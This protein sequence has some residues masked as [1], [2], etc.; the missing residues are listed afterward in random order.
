MM[1]RS[2][3]LMVTAVLCTAFSVSVDANLTG[4]FKSILLDGNLDDWSN[5]AD[6]LYDPVEISTDGSPTNSV[7][8]N[9]YL[10]NDAANLYVALEMKGT[11][12]ADITN[13]WRH[14]IYLDTDSFGGTG[15]NAGWMSHGYDRLIQYGAGGA[16]TVYE[17]TGG[18]LEE[19]GWNSLGT[20]AYASD[21]NIVEFSIPLTTLNLSTNSFV[22]ELSVVE[23]GVT[24]ETWAH[25]NEVSAET[26]TLAEFSG[27][28]PTITVDGSLEEWDNPGHILYT[29]AEIAD[30]APANSSYENVYV[31]NDAATLYIGLDTKGTGGGSVSNTWTHNIYLDT[32]MNSGT[33][34]KGGGKWMTYGYDRLIQYGTGGTTYSVYEFTGADQGDWEWNFLAEI[35]YAYSDDVIEMS[36]PMYLLNLS[37]NT[38]VMELNVTGGEVTT[39]TWA[40]QWESGAKTYT[41]LDNGEEPPI[42]PIGSIVIAGP[43]SIPG[44]QGMALSWNTAAGQSYS[45]EHTFN[46]TS[47]LDWDVYT[48][49]VGS[50]GGMTVTTSVDQAKSFYQ[51]V[52]P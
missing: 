15:F 20:F 23:G 38:L 32:D 1:K 45:V 49:V 7:Y 34:F 41:V 6:V 9:V 30:G 50:G 19:W 12:G 21:D 4:T 35:T 17:F 52:S 33:G 13:S 22:M 28:Y 51:V 16:Y 14:N 26:Y 42:I 8:E 29:D 27:S 44:G 2:M 25:V 47:L 40:Y 39:P 48:N 3:S 36:V 11:G 46:L 24:T 43:V 10:A 37:T 18:T 31:V 5:P